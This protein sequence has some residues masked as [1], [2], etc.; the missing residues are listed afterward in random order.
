M[1]LVSSLRLRLVFALGVLSVSGVVQGI[2]SNSV[3]RRRQV[4]SRYQWY[5]RRLESDDAAG[6]L[7]EDIV[8]DFGLGSV[9]NSNSNELSQ[10]HATGGNVEPISTPQPSLVDESRNR[11]TDSDS[12]TAVVHVG[13]HKTGT[14]SIQS[15]I[16]RTLP[17]LKKDGYSVPGNWSHS[18]LAVNMADLVSCF[19]KDQFKDTASGTCD[20]DA[21]R[22]METIAHE[23]GN[24]LLTAEAFAYDITD[25]NK[26]TSALEPWKDSTI[27]VVYYRRFYEWI[28]SYYN[29]ET[30]YRPL[31]QRKSFVEWLSDVQFIENHYNNMY[32]YGVVQ[33][34]KQYFN[35]VKVYNM[36]DTSKEIIA[37][38]MCEAIPNAPNACEE[39]TTRLR[40]KGELVFNPSTGALVYSELVYAAYQMGLLNVSGFDD[41]NYNETLWK[42]IISM[43]QNRQEIELGL[44][45]HEFLEILCPEKSVLDRILELSLDVERE[46]FPEYFQSE[47]G[48]PVIR[49]QFDSEKRDPRKLCSVDAKSTLE[50]DSG[51]RAFFMSFPGV[52]V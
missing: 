11:N 33:R 30:R 9:I 46:L 28:C 32:T 2:D 48:E 39:T 1:Q 37:E 34:W 25:M 6:V 27:I 21:L 29:M 41:N 23:N 3:R 49:Q 47:Y 35:N 17:E 5:N 40:N 51:W 38:F 15:M 43:T 8:E 45:S 36:H 14:T 20:T 44:K 10:L 22:E 13:P 50:N 31:H 16:L 18:K 42:E 19:W 26:V 7:L 24:L 4:R 12:M 52:P